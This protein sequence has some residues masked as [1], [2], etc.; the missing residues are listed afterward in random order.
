MSYD[1]PQPRHEVHVSAGTAFKVG[2]FGFFGAFVASLILSAI[3]FVILLV[4]GLVLGATTAGLFG[5]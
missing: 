5:S 4:I 2:F 1:I 3:G